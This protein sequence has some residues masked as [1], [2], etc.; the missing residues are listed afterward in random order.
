MSRLDTVRYD[1]SL[2][3]DRDIYLFREGTHC[4]LYNKLGS[5]EKTVN[6]G[7]SHFYGVGKLLFL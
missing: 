4:H 7:G 5:H 3:T 6:G 2:L 1:V